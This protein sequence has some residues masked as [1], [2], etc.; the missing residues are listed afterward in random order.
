VIAAVRA[1]RVEMIG[2]ADDDQRRQKS[3]LPHERHDVGD[4]L[5]VPVAVEHVERFVACRG[6]GGGF[7]RKIDIDRALLVQHVRVEAVAARRQQRLGGGSKCRCRKQHEQEDRCEQPTHL[8]IIRV[9][10]SC[11][12]TL[13]VGRTAVR[14]VLGRRTASGDT[15]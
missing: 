6:I 7:F 3:D 4:K 5:G 11:R 15:R 12:A 9:R 14:T 10:R 1:V 13:Q 2:H 8:A